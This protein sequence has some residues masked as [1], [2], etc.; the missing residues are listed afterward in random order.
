MPARAMT[1]LFLPA[2][3][4]VSSITEPV[5][6]V[7]TPIRLFKEVLLPAPLR[8]SSATTSFFSHPQADVEQDVRIAVVAVQPLDFEQAHA[9]SVRRSF[10]RGNIA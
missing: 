1:W 9:G 3:S 5:R 10:R 6:G 4:T 2:S 8:P 7:T